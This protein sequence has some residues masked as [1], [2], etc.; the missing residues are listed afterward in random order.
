M[1]H[2]SCQCKD[3]ITKKQERGEGWVREDLDHSV[4]LTLEDLLEEAGC[5]KQCLSILHP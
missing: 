1:G 4:S 5:C 3:K 2:T